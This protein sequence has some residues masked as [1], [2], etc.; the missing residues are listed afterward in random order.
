[1][2]ITYINKHLHE[3]ID[4]DQLCRIACM[5]RTK[6]FN[7]FKLQFGC[8]PLAFQQ[9]QRL[10]KAAELIKTGMQITQVSFELGFISSSH[11]SRIF[12]R[13]YGISPKSYQHRH[14]TMLN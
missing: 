13:F 10:K 9:Q 6:F 4:I 11:F 7:Q 5:C 14:K 3:C 1:M 8:T 12:K 2:V